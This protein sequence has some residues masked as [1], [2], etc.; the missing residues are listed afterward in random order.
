M[1]ASILWK[2]TSERGNIPGIRNLGVIFCTNILI[3][4][5]ELP[6]TPGSDAAGYVHHVGSNVTNIKV[7]TV[8]LGISNMFSKIRLNLLPF[9][10]WRKSLCE[11]D[12]QQFWIL[13][14]VHS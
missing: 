5:P 9:L 8:V 1:L 7:M 4:L 3:R 12:K 14:G 11:W 10:G 2:H 13:R 6:Y